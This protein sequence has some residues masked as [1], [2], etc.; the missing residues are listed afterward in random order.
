[1]PTK[2]ATNGVAGRSYTSRAGPDLLDAAGVEHDDPVGE[3]ECLVLVVG[4]EHERDAGGPLDLLQLD[5]HLLAQLEVECA[6]RFVEQEH[7]R[8]SDQR[9]GQGDPLPLTPDSAAGDRSAIPSSRTVA[10]ASIARSRR[11]TRGTFAI[12]SGY[13][14]LR[15]TDRCGKSA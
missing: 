10:S 9:A 8:A 5:L 12:R 15:R 11:F 1:M 3:G 6:E 2:P 4:D 14:T 7:R 13:S